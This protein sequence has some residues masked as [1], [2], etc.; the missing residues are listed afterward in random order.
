MMAAG[1]VLSYLATIAPFGFHR[2]ATVFLLVNL[3][4]LVPKVASWALAAHGFLGHPGLRYKRWRLAA[5]LWLGTYTASLVLTVSLYL[6]SR[7]DLPYMNYDLAFAVSAIYPLANMAFALLVTRAFGPS[8]AAYGRGRLLGWAF[9]IYGVGGVA[10]WLVQS[11]AVIWRPGALLNIHQI[12]ML[13]AAIAATVAFFRAAPPGSPPNPTS[14]TRRERGLAIAALFL[15]LHYAASA[16]TT[17]YLL[18][19]TR[20]WFYWTGLA[21]QQWFTLASVVTTLVAAGFAVKA[22]VVSRRRLLIQA[23][24]SHWSVTPSE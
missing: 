7:S 5:W 19:R 16:A 11:L 18:H 14:I 21:A 23:R 9:L 1:A 8:T 22:F 4:F 20:D 3:A 12:L 2:G 6:P 13:G 24:T 10:S 15:V 17:A